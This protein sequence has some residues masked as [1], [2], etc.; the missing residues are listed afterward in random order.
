[1]ILK[2]CHNSF[3][4]RSAVCCSKLS[5]TNG[6][7]G[8]SSHCALHRVFDRAEP[9]LGQPA[10]VGFNLITLP[11]LTVTRRPAPTPVIEVPEPCSL[12]A[13]SRVFGWLSAAARR[14][15][16]RVPCK[17]IAR[18][19][20]AR[21]LAAG[22]GPEMDMGRSHSFDALHHQAAVGTAK[23]EVAVADVDRSPHIVCIR[24]CVD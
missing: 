9:Q 22:S 17:K 18:D 2:S 11:D 21:L 4:G 19:C 14:V 24:L 16:L 3:R 10:L 6:K 15:R 1:M 13:L 7:S 8:P 5:A 23:N 12:V 20:L